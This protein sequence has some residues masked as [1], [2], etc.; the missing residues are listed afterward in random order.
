MSKFEMDDVDLDGLGKSEDEINEILESG[1]EA[2]IE[3]LLG[4]GDESSEAETKTPEASDGDKGNDDQEETTSEEEGDSDAGKQGDNDGTPPDADQPG[5][6][7][8]DSDGDSERYVESRNGQHK[9]PYAVLQNAR[10]RASALHNRTEELQQNLSG[11]QA[12]LAQ[13]KSVNDQLKQQLQANNLTPADVLQ[14]VDIDDEMLET[15][16][17]YG[18]LGEVVR[19]LALQNQQLQEAISQD[20]ENA[21]PPVPDQGP[22]AMQQQVETAIAD[23]PSLSDW[24]QND[25]D[26]WEMAIIVDEKLKQ[27]PAFKEASFEERFKEVVKRTQAAFGVPDK[28]QDEPGQS[29]KTPDQ[30]DQDAQALADKAKA[31]V[32]EATKNQFPQ[33]LTDIGHSSTAEKSRLDQFSEMS[34][35]E[36]A[37]A[38]ENMSQDQIE[39]LMAELGE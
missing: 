36:L 6:Q 4:F 16:S 15:L 34:E 32:E 14:K 20:R 39:S 2:A 27:D 10:E 21:V 25:P 38:M 33:S 5:E 18:N 37:V 1:D 35:A 19:A 26:K 23:N 13:L 8:T 30:S 3:A 17:E 22:D 12:E 24:R 9:I 31:K 29:K 7:P 28:P 11:T